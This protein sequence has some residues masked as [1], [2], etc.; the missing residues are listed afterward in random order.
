ME[1]NIVTD[2]LKNIINKI[3]YKGI[4]DS[5]KSLLIETCKDNV[6]CF[7]CNPVY[8]IELK[9]TIPADI[10]EEGRTLIPNSLF[11]VIQAINADAIIITDNGIEYGENTI[12]Y[13]PIDTREFIKVDK[14]KRKNL[15][16]SIPE[17]ELYGL[18]KSTFYAVAIDET[19]PILTGLNFNKNNVAALDGYRLAVSES[20]EFNIDGSITLSCQTIKAL[21]KIL[22]KKS[23]DIVNFYIT[24]NQDFIIIEINNITVTAHLL[25]GNYIKYDSII[26]EDHDY[27]IEI[28]VKELLKKLKF[29]FELKKS[30]PEIVR[31]TID[32]TQLYI[33]NNNSSADIK[34]SIGINVIEHGYLPFSIAFNPLYL[35]DALK[36]CNVLAIMQFSTSVSPALIKAN[37]NLDL[38]LPIRFKE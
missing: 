33:E 32:H 31:L 9:M 5:Q 34:D 4:A 3:T 20:K 12:K 27:E 23:D 11:K 21:L 18:I 29:M 26:P 2:E 22:D 38:V 7:V 6:E 17:K 28:D 36:K 30:V 35:R 8:A 1:V 10:I 14:D 16:F 13:V 19:R 37:N 24:Q 25:D 15:L